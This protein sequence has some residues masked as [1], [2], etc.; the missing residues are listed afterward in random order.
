MV[1]SERFR[2]LFPITET[3]AYLFAGGL[4]PAAIPV[5]AALDEWS[6]RWM[7]DPAYHRARYFEEW[8]L[9]KDRLASVLGADPGE[10]AIVDNT[11]RGSNLAVQMIEPSPGANIVTD[12]TS[13]P[14]AVW[15]WL[16]PGRTPV[17][18]RSIPAGPPSTWADGIEAAVD[19]RTVAVIVSHVD[20]RTG[21]RHDLRRLADLAH[22][23]DGYLIVDAA[24]S[25]GAV[26]IDAEGD[27]VDFM[28]G[29]VMKWLLGPPGLGYLYAR[30]EH[31]EALP[32]P[33]V[34]YVG[35]EAIGNPVA[36]DHLSFG[37][38][39]IRHEIGLADLPA[40]AA[41]RQGLDIILEAGIP[42]VEEHVLD[43]TGLMVEGLEDRGIEVLTPRDRS[44]RAGVVAFHFE[45]AVSLCRY[46]RR[47][48]V[49]VWGYDEDDR[50][51]ADP[52]LY[53]TPDDVERLLEGID[54]FK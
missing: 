54:A 14:S 9:V 36:F 28:S 41:A 21:F 48:G 27:G 47:R 38:G 5:K 39:A 44:G 22:S 43:L 13:H 35:T 52:H 3:R 10:L 2:P 45:G 51:R 33:H 50:V 19:E 1:L 29:T 42:A 23:V 24:Q 37:P 34:G 46:L 40:I 7:F 17:E 30:R 53:N 18:I 12:P 49:D 8:R 25:A 20:A 31:L 4:A 11:S 32:P 16:L 15:P 26:P 6:D